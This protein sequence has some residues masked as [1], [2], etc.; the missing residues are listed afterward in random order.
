MTISSKIQD[1][2][3]IVKNGEFLVCE[4]QILLIKYVEN[5]FKNENLYVDEKQLDDY[6]S[7]QKYFDYDLFP[8]EKF[9]FALHNCTY[10]APGILRWPKLGLTIDKVESGDTDDDDKL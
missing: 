6:L 8:W 5:C 3:D 7:L 10:S 1:Y 4:E 2:I 9:V